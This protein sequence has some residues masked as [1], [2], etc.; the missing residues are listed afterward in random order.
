MSLESQLLQFLFAG[1]T[2]GS[3]YA[4]IA[5]G[6]VTIHNVTGIVNFAQGDFAMLGAL[7]TVTL[8][9]R[10]GLFNRSITVDLN[11]PLP[12][13]ALVAVLITTL[14]GVL[15]YLLAIR[16][17]RGASIISLI[18]ITI[19][20][21]ITIEGTGLLIWWTDPYPLPVFTAGPPLEIAG[22][23][24]TRQ[25]LWVIGTAALIVV[26]LYLFFEHTL[27][28]KALRACAVNWGAARLMGINADRMALFSFALGAAIS[29]VA[30]IV[31]T[32]MTYMAYDSGL[33]LSLKGFVAAIMGGLVSFPLAIA[34]GL[35]LGLV[36]AFGAGLLSSAYKDAF[37]F[38]AMF[39]ILLLR[40][41]GLFGDQASQETGLLRGAEQSGV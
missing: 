33:L 39:L 13:A 25:N 30:G 31:I 10:T 16:P 12:V 5:L 26:G 32:P 41:G 17:A 7:I 29:A 21:S 27:T 18:I 8:Y 37:A 36:E 11:W 2:L 38:L 35:V 40:V 23:F 22:A 15:F 19:G 9:K 4:L 3:I 14:I 34:G 1:L 20:A 24:I 6:F 28:G